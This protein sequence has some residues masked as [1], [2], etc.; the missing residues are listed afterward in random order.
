MNKNLCDSDCIPTIH[1]DFWA[2]QKQIC[3][4]RRK[5]IGRKI[6]VATNTDEYTDLWDIVYAEDENEDE[7]EQ[8]AD[9]VSETVY[10]EGEIMRCATP[11]D[12][13]VKKYYDLW[14]YMYLCKFPHREEGVWINMDDCAGD[15]YPDDYNDFDSV[16]TRW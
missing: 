12:F 16:Y 14:H 4:R 8:Y 3:W 11:D 13:P 15:W 10:L 2:C 6:K 9:P 5:I 1:E 7:K